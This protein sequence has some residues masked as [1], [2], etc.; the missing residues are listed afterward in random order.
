MGQTTSSTQHYPAS[1]SSATCPVDHS[2]F[3]RHQH[4]Q[5]SSSASASCPVD[6]ASLAKHAQSSSSAARCPVDHAS[7]S[8][9]SS[10]TAAQCPVQPETLDPRNNLPILTQSRAPSQ[11]VDLPTDRTTSSIPRATADNWEYPSP[12]QF[13]NAL[14][15]KGW[16]TPENEIETMVHIHNFLNEKAWEEVQKWEAQVNKC[17]DLLYLSCLSNV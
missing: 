9:S 5:A 7:S 8:K 10:T 1:S 11:T 13:Y 12:Q 15:R 3:A 6:H 16:E 17:V 4:P 2:T 14:V